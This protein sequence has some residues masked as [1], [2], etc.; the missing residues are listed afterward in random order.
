MDKKT[1]LQLN[2]FAK[3]IRLNTVRSLDRLGFGHYGGSLSI[4]ETLAVLYDSILQI[5][6]SNPKLPTRDYFILSKGHAGPALYAALALKGYFDMDML[7]T[8]NQNGTNLPS[9]PDRNLTPGVD[10]TTGSLGQGISVACGV[11]KSFQI[12]HKDQ[13]VY[14]I[15]GDGELNEGQCW[16]AFQFA[17]HN[18]LDHLIVFLDENKKQLDGLTEQISGGSS[19]EEKFRAF[20]FDTKRVLGNDVEAIHDAIIDAKAV[21]GKPHIIILDT[22]KGQGFPYLETLESNH[23]LRPTIKEDEI[24][25]EYIKQLESELGGEANA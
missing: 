18:Q 10:M 3:E 24:I 23:H 22:I 4:V 13:Y 17:G 21:P 2:R 9:H 16:E 14:C 15:V 25:K 19:Y 5:D 8:L 7:Y 20:G 11:A 6:P 12:D 1:V